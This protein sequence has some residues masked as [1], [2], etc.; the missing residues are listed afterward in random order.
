MEAVRQAA[1]VFLGGG[2][3]AVAR[4][5]M[6][7]LVQSK[8]A[9]T[10]PW[11]TLAVNTLGSFLIGLVMG[12]LLARG[13]DQSWRLLLVTGVLGGFTTFSAFS[14]ETVQLVSNRHLAMAGWYVA[15]SVLLCLGASSLGVMCA[16]SYA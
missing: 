7:S 3:G 4:F 13:W 5:W 1:L 15:A 6:G 16:R 10:F 2:S 11:G 8:V 12:L 14:Y 9:G